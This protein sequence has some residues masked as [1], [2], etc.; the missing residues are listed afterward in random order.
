MRLPIR[1]LTAAEFDQCLLAGDRRQ[2]LLLYRPAC[3]DCNA[4]VP[5][6]LDLQEFSPTSSQRRARRVG[7]RTLTV[8]LGRPSV[9]EARVSLYNLHKTSRGLDGGDPDITAAEYAAFLVE[10]CV[11]SWELS[12]WV[13]SQ[14]VGVAVFDRSEV[15]LSAVYC[16]YD[17]RVQGLSIGTFSVMHQ[18]SL[19]RQW[20]LRWLYLGYVVDA[21]DAM[22]YKASYLPHERRVGGS[23][24]V[25]ERSDAV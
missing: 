1:R 11:D 25:V 8:C 17:P 3:P 21:C 23:W 19:G 4:C 14:L 15:A 10:T 5:I 12:Y 16:H 2:G 13:G 6:R 9:D 24:Q 20:G 7:E 22:R 18:V